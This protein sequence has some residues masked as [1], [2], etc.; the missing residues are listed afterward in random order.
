MSIPT[1]PPLPP[2]KQ[3]ASTS[4][5]QKLNVAKGFT[6]QQK[7]QTPGPA[8]IVASAPPISKAAIFG[9]LMGAMLLMIGI[10]NFG[11][12]E[13]RDLGAFAGA[14][15]GIKQTTGLIYFAA[16]INTCMIATICQHTK[17]DN[18]P[19]YDK[20]KEIAGAP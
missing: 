6:G 10:W 12:G 5:E 9:Y 19:I 14:A 2:K 3:S 17:K 20:L 1:P 8:E 7:V 16:G 18:N 4:S 11:A 15:K 13:N